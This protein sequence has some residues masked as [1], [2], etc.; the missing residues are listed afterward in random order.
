MM[1]IE[2]LSGIIAGQQGEVAFTAPLSRM[3]E[4]EQLFQGMLKLSIPGTTSVETSNS[5][6]GGTGSGGGGCCD[7]HSNSLQCTYYSLKAALL[8]VTGNLVNARAY[9]QECISVATDAHTI[10]KICSINHALALALV[11]KLY[12]MASDFIAVF[13]VL[14]LMQAFSKMFDSTSAITW[15]ARNCLPQQ[16]RVADQLVSQPSVDVLSTRRYRFSVTICNGI[17]SF[18]ATSRRS[19]LRRAYHNHH[20]VNLKYSRR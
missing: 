12:L 11:G 19:S 17:N 6:G 7:S 16:Y 9:A 1:R 3:A 20:Q 15:K 10:C 4:F 2:I 18:I 5:S 13:G 14:C 8:V